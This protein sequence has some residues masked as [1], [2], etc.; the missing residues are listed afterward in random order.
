M[1]PGAFGMSKYPLKVTSKKTA[2]REA[3]PGAV[4]VA[5]PVPRS[6]GFSSFRYSYTEF[7]SQGGRTR[8]KTK[9][10]RLEDGKLSTEAFE[11]ELDGDV[12]DEVV[13]QAQQQLL[14]QAAWLLRSMSWLLPPM[15][16]T[17]SDRE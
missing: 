6:G 10:A 8:V 17:R 13:R 15:R 16:G 4:E 12:Y 2:L 1:H 9:Q 7:S 14:G 3:D 5:T 11:G